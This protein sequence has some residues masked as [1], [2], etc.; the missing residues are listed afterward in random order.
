M[1]NGL[2]LPTVSRLQTNGPVSSYMTEIN[3]E[4]KQYVEES[5]IPRYDSFDKGHGRG[6]VCTVI[7]QALELS[8][9]YDVDTDMIYVAAA[10]HDTG[11]CEGRE[12]HHTVSARIIREDQ[13]LRRWFTPEQIETIADAAEDHRASSEREPRTIYGLIIAE[14]DREIVPDTIIKRTIQYGIDHYPALDREGH[15]QRMLEHL[16]EKY[17]DG[18]YLKLWIPESSNRAKLEDLRAIIRDETRLRSIFEKVFD[19]E[20][21][22]V[23]PL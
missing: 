22:A 11:I 12:R 5:I 16:H 23:N 2:S 21:S 8:R 17:A 18:G 13:N 9:H 19:A 15:W 4:I 6:H 20:V 14:A 10:Y 7:G 3:K 1:K